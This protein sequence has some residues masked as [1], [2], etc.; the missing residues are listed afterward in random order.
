LNLIRVMP[1]KEGAMPAGSSFDVVV[2]GGGVV[3]LASAWRAS[4]RGARVCVLER[5]RPGQGASGTAAGI[6]APDTDTEPG[7]EAFVAL[8]HR[9]GELYPSFVAELEAAT[10]HD[11][12][13][14][15]SGTLLVALDR[16]EVAA[17]RRE[18]DLH[19]RLGLTSE[20]LGASECRRLEPGLSPACT[21]GLHV[22]HEGHVD[23][24]RLVAALVDA[25]RVGGSDVRAGAEV[26]R[27]LVD[28]GRLRG[29]VTATGDEIR[30]ERVVLAGGA[31]AASAGL[32]A[33]PP[34]VRPVKGQILRLRA[35]EGS[36][37][38][39]RMVRS[40]WVY[41][42]TRRSGEVLV[43]ATVEERGFDT[44]VTAGGVHELLREAYRALPEVAELEL[45]EA[46]SSLRPATADGDPLIGEWGDEGL[47]VALG[48]FR[49]GI[50]LAPITADAVAA[51]LAGDPAPPETG[52]FAPA[53]KAAR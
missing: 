31:W 8:A 27:G 20:W 2:V 33:D 25:V 39:S 52:P 46:S 47:V 23:P 18:L 9:S 26:V 6:L 1:A 21:G 30:G 34:P 12:G 7:R 32:T 41:V 42:V 51:L 17:V 29:V 48:H 16:D 40:E 19:R 11:V 53:Q 15:R 36:L 10:G 28:G 49:N 24:R 44:T 3:G 4:Q 13:H 14:E 37:P 38:A 5:G 43:G 45:V 35:H 22:P 50:L